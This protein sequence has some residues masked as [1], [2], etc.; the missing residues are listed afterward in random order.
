MADEDAPFAA[1]LPAMAL[2]AG[3][4]VAG[5]FRLE[6]IVGEGASGVVWA[7]HD[8]TNREA[9]AL[10]VLKRLSRAD[11]LR[12]DRE[13]R[14]LASLEHPHILALRE[15][16]VAADGEDV[17]LVTDL[18]DGETLASRL[19]REG[20]VPHDDAARLLLPLARALRHAHA[21]GVAHR[22]LKPSNVFL[23]RGRGVVLLDFGLSK[24]T[25]AR[26]PGASSVL[27]ESGVVL[28]TPHYMA[29][30][31]LL[32]A[33]EVDAA[34][35]V[36]ALGVVAFEM[37]AGAH[38]IAGASFAHVVS[39]LEARALPRL[40][41]R[42]P[43]VPPP[44]VALVESMLTYDRESRARIEDVVAALERFVVQSAAPSAPSAPPSAP[45]FTPP[46]VPASPADGPQKR[47]IVSTND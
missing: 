44:L 46:S 10:K 43:D 37:L 19:A 11:R 15:R 31:Q 26:D 24:R 25:A 8:E 2:T 3:D 28:G 41:S 13:A 20:A 42:T 4:R 7:A 38:P 40:A 9:V 5:R 34:A 14:L 22:D 18:L 47:R 12:L 21:H 39:V 36:W 27:T 23:A 16:V 30:E 1:R 45:P 17:V 35:D 32:S 29:P 33:R 6:R